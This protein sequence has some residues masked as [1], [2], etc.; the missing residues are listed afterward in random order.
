MAEREL[1]HATVRREYQQIPELFCRPSLLNQVFLNLLLNAGHALTESGSEI[2]LK[3]W[4]DTTSVY[5]SVSDSGKGIPE[6]VRSRV[7]EPFFT[8]RDV[9]KGTGLG[10]STCYEIVK[11]HEGE[12]MV[13]SE[14]GSG[15]TFTIRLP[16]TTPLVS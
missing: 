14:P 9:G 5:A 13:E 7:F 10:L 1:R 12:I 6:E 16:R 8:T 3:C 4:S 15:T 2:V 11:A